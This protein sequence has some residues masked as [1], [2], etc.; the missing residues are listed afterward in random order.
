LVGPISIIAGT[1]VTNI[2]AKFYA[3]SPKVH[4]LVTKSLH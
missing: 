1:G 3:F 4:N 2:C